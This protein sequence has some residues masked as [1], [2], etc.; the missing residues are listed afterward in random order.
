VTV[1]PSRSVFPNRR[2]DNVVKFTSESL[3]R[4]WRA[5]GFPTPPRLFVATAS[6]TND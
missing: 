4:V 2:R 6:S 3:D 1:K 5:A